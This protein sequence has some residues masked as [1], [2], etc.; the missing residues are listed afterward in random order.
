MNQGWIFNLIF[1][2]LKNDRVGSKIPILIQQRFL[3]R[4][5]RSSDDLKRL[6]ISETEAAV[7]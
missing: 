4:G 6:A 1:G 2:M 7:S 3:D 5:V